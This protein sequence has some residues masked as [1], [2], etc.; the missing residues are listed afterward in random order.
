MQFHDRSSRVHFAD[1]ADVLC[2]EGSLGKTFEAMLIIAQ[3]WYEGGDKILVAVPTPLLAQW[4]DVL[5]GH[6]SLPYHVVDNGKAWEEA[7]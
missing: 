1:R 3:R 6:F 2:D 7:I 4:A 5:E